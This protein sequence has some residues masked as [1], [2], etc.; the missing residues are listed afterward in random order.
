MSEESAESGGAELPAVR[1]GR[2]VEFIESMR[3]ASVHEIAEQFEVSADTVRRDL[4]ELHK[5]GH[6][7]RT[8]GGA[9]ANSVITSPDRELRI[10]QQL[11]E[12]EKKHIGALTAT[13]IPHGAV[14]AFNG[15]TTTLAVA[16]SLTDHR[17]L[18]I[19][20]NNLS[21][22]F[23]VPT[24]AVRNLYIFGGDVRFSSQVTVGQ[25][26]FPDLGD[27]GAVHFDIAVIGVGG[28]THEGFSVS[29]LGEASMMRHLIKRSSRIVVVADS[30][31]FNRP[32]F[33]LVA[34]LS[35]AH[36]LVT[37]GEPPAALRSI[38]DELGLTVHQARPPAARNV[39]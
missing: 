8:R 24:H 26:S 12:P 21:I 33:A 17:D 9:I 19:A 5:D 11:Q 36:D 7:S 39:R 38:F 29:N 15:G 16:R 2:I 10:R 13:L 23:D 35:A 20:T 14:I 18:T 28:I 34:P 4:I 31:K 1:R 32:Q 3:Q 30:T 6:V 22:P 27:P 37:D 25:A